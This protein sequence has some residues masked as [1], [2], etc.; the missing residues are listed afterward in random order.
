M[1][2]KSLVLVT[3]AAS[4]AFTAPVRADSTAKP[5]SCAGVQWKDPRTANS[6]V[7]VVERNGKPYVK[8]SGKVVKKGKISLTVLLDKSKEELTWMPDLGEMV[9]INGKEVDPM[10][11]E[12]GTELH[13]YVPKA[14]VATQ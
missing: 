2:N 7:A 14:Q 3:I 9:T 12:I 10:T 8:L 1:T 4:L 11:V 13:F 6:C 5:D